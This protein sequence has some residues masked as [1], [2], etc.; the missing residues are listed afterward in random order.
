MV[1][2]E[3]RSVSEE[4]LAHPESLRH[5]IKSGLLFAVSN[6]TQVQIIET[7]GDWIRVIVTE[8]QMRGKIC[9]D[10]KQTS[11]IVEACCSKAVI[12]LV[13]WG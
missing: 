7:Q 9:V 6:G 5:F 2:A 12:A 10:S 4:L 3:D 11:A 8:G 13:L 1:L